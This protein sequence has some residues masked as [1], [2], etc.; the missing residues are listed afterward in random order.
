MFSC[1]I[2][3]CLLRYVCFFKGSPSI[4]HR[5]FLLP[6]VLLIPLGCFGVS[7]CVL[8]IS[9]ADVTCLDIMELDRTW[10]VVLQINTFEKPF[11]EIMTWLLNLVHSSCCEQFNYFLPE[12]PGLL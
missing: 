5:F 1:T 6:V 9:V 8:E 11:P 10:V 12:K 2:L 7:R 4:K 3:K